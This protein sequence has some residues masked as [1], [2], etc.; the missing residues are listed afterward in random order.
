MLKTIAISNQKG[1]SGKTTTAVSV[2]AALGEQGKRI[3]VIDLDPQASASAWCGVKNGNRGLLD[4][5]TDGASLAD[6][7]CTTDIECVDVIP[8]SSW[9][10]NAERA[11]AGEVGAEL[12][13]KKCIKK[14]P[15][16][17][18]DFVLL[19]CPPTLGLLTICALAASQEV[20]VPVECHVMALHGVAQLART[21]EVVRERLN[22][23]LQVSAIL[24][25]RVDRRTRHSLEVA[26][27]LRNRFGRR[28]LDAVVRE[29]VKLAEAPSFARPI[30]SYAPKSRGAEDYRCVAA[31]LLK[32]WRP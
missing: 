24:L 13:L 32:K 12:A 23:S 27:T 30:T 6:L 19:D 14:L 7:V 21:V 4:V 2:A 25:C 3:L 28:V 17:R 20:L 29:N 22:P 31:E 10:G 1:G 11:L 18:W 9:L 26:Q 5:L 8:A 15:R 16:G